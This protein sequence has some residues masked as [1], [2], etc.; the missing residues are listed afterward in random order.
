M[1]RRNGY[2]IDEARWGENMSQFQNSDADF[3]RE[4]RKQVELRGPMSFVGCKEVNL[5]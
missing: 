4:K 1:A 2:K 5:A 3:N